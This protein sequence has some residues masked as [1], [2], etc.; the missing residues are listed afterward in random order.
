MQRPLHGSAAAALA[1]FSREQ[2]I[3]AVQAA[4]LL[5]D[6]NSDSG[7]WSMSALSQRDRQSAPI[8]KVNL[9]VTRDVRVGYLNIIMA[10]G[11]K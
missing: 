2:G 7:M 3:W 9:V 4:K 10:E 8:D 1:E 11:D 6:E 5:T